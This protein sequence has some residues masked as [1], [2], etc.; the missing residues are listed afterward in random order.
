LALSD[1]RK[2]TL[3]RIACNVSAHLLTRC[4]D[5]AS[6]PCIRRQLRVPMKSVKVNAQSLRPDE[7]AYC[8]RMNDQLSPAL[9]SASCVPPTREF[10]KGALCAVGAVSIWAGWLVGMRLGVT[11]HLTRSGGIA[12]CCR[13]FATIAGAVV[14]GTWPASARLVRCVCAGAGRR[15]TVRVGRR[16]R[17]VV[18][19]VAHASVFT[20]G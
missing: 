5:K 11:T 12:I 20:Q 6:R 19:P 8:N 18:C 9:A 4:R 1:L 13:W 16:L 14:A 10:L 2:S 7:E 15:R 3:L 17:F